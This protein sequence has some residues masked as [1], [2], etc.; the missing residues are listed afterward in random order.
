MYVIVK[1]ATC[2]GICTIQVQIEGRLE[3]L[4]AFES[5]NVWPVRMVCLST[6]AC[7]PLLKDT[8]QQV[9]LKWRDVEFW[10]RNQRLYSFFLFGTAWQWLLKSH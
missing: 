3:E 10:S 1:E 8:G 4:T 7:N 6:S 9:T 5:D 2:N